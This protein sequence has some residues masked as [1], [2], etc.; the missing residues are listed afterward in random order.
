[1]WWT[2]GRPACPASSRAWAW[3][4]WSG[5]ASR[6]PRRTSARAARAALDRA[7]ACACGA[8]LEHQRDARGGGA[9]A[10]AERPRADGPGAAG[11]GRR[12]RARFG[13]FEAPPPEALEQADALLR[14]LA[15]VDPH[16]LTPSGR[17]ALAMPLHPRL[18]AVVA[19][20]HAAGALRAVCTAAALVNERDVLRDPP[21]MVAE[22]DLAL[23]LDALAEAEAARLRPRR[24]PAVGARRRA[25]RARCIQRPGP[26]P[27][28]GDPR[29][30]PGPGPGARGRRPGG[31]ET[32][33]RSLL[34]G[35]GDR[36]AQRRGRAEQ[37]GSSWPGAGAPCWIPTS[38]VREAELD[39]RRGPGGRRPR[40]GRASI[41][42]PAWPARVSPAWLPVV[43]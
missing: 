35:F 42:H 28:R 15:F 4:A 30:R 24:L 43:R 19:A 29:A 26:A 21:D 23:R 36:V 5:C 10:A 6:R 18:A 17:A 34:A 32:V 40:H 9:G 2:R 7:A 14:R 41:K 8:A 3:S 33:L 12:A 37:R 20:G 27:G 25:P 39:A 13:F 11:L 38:V 1:V 22:S 31:R 16:G